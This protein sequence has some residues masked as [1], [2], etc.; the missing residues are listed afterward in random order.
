MSIDGLL[1][2]LWGWEVLEEGDDIG[3]G[4][5]EVDNDTNLHIPY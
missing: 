2:W 4:E 3:Y 5:E 1:Y